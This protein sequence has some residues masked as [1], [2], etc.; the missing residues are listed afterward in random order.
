MVKKY[1]DILRM[2]KYVFPHATDVNILITTSKGESTLF[3][4]DVK[5]LI[6]DLSLPEVSSAYTTVT[7]SC[8]GFNGKIFVTSDK[9]NK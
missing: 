7:G 3:E 2:V 4:S 1:S 5:E 6:P 8:I 9:P